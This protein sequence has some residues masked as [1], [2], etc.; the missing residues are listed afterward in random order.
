MNDLMQEIQSLALFYSI[1]Q[2]KVIKSLMNAMAD[3]KEEPL[4]YHNLLESG[5]TDDWSGYV[6]NLVRYD[7][8]I[9]AKSLAKKEPIPPQIKQ[10]AVEELKILKNLSEQSSDTLF[11]NSPYVW[12][13]KDK[14]IFEYDALAEDISKNGYGIYARYDAFVFQDRELVPIPNP[15]KIDL[16]SLIGYQTQRQ[17]VIANTKAFIEGKPANNVLL[18]GDRGSGKSSTIVG[19]FNMFKGQIKLI[20][21]PLT[22]LK[23]ITYLMDML[24][25]IPQRFI[26]FLDDLV[27]DKNNSESFYPLKAALEGSFL[28][29]KTNTLIYATSNRRHLVKQ[30]QKDREDE[31][32]PS[33]GLEDT[34][35]LAD[36]FGLVVLFHNLN[37]DEYLDFIAKLA[38]NNNIPVTERLLKDAELWALAK[39]VRSP[40]TAVQ[41]IN[42]IIGAE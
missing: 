6:Y 24:R 28:N 18:T 31:V 41:F 20:E 35:A 30:S 15:P 23:N 13:S 19:V 32:R 4:F 38:Q 7:E 21:L 3:S 39:A 33:E 8:N 16:N 34:L 11:K 29:S 22:N 40:R 17:E 36:R 42:S 27:V 37:K 12:G 9:W 1:K 2:D 10:R 5:Y 14:Y 25:E 26:I